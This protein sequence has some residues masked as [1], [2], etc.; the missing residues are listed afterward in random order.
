VVVRNNTLLTEPQCD[1][2]LI[3]ISNSKESDE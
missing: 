1:P 3:L 2:I